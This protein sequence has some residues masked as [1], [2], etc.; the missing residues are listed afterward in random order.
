M[1]SLGLIQDHIISHEADAA[2]GQ[3]R[4]CG[5]LD[6]SGMRTK[7]T[8]KCMDCSFSA[9]TCSDCFLDQHVARFTHWA[10][11]WNDTVGCFVRQDISCLGYV[12]NL[13]HNGKPCPHAVPGSD[14]F[15]HLVDINGVHDTKLRFCNCVPKV[16]RASQL[17]KHRLFPA[18]IPQ[19][20]MAFTFQLLDLYSMIHVESKITP[21]DFIGSIRRMT[22]NSFTRIV[23]VSTS[24]CWLKILLYLTTYQISQESLFPVLLGLS[25]LE[26]VGEQEAAR[27]LS[28]YQSIPGA[29]G[30]AAR[31]TSCLL[32]Y[33]ST[34]A[35]EHG[36]NL[37]GHTE[38]ST[39]LYISYIFANISDRISADI[40][41]SFNGR[42]MEISS[43]VNSPRILIPIIFPCMTVTHIFLVRKIIKLI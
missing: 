5:R 38:T 23:T 4:P 14:L 31:L 2:I 25:S 22:D 9:A 11:V 15:F 36:T 41:T 30:T 8:T 17:L 6:A 40:S 34:S 13:G 37:E 32:S 26:L 1:E 24:V 42:L 21:Y 28:R 18:T 16:D 10:H 12:I 29:A 35:Y 43:S 33:M 27:T 19:P 7:V 3:E 20:K 39:V